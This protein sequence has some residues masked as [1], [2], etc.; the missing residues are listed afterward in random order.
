MKAR[1]WFREIPGAGRCDGSLVR[2]HLIPKQ[3]LKREFPKG[4]CRVIEEIGGDP[5][6]PTHAPPGPWMKVERAHLEAT[7][8]EYRSLH[9]LI[10]DPRIWRWGCGGPTGI[11]GHHGKVDGLQLRISRYKLPQS[12]EEFADELGITWWLDRTYGPL[13][14][15][16]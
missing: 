8:L 4:V 9:A 3:F 11:G 2:A 14:A 16:E 10:S 6:A 7:G 13:Q 12:V 5:E 15:P 1:C